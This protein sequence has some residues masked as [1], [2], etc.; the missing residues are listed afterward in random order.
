MD[1]FSNHHFFINITTMTGM[2]NSLHYIV[3]SYVA[4]FSLDTLFCSKPMF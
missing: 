2:V 3:S 4:C 1:I